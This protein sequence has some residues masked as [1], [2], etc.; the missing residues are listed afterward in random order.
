LFVIKLQ[1][2]TVV[3]YLGGTIFFDCPV[4]VFAINLSPLPACVD[5]LNTA[6]LI[7]DRVWAINLADFDLFHFMPNPALFSSRFWAMDF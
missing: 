3:C 1:S 5:E 6:A 7:F 4:R 2:R